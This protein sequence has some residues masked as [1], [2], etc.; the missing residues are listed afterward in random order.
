[1]PRG[2]QIF[3]LTAR[4]MFYRWRGKLSGRGMSGDGIRLRGKCPPVSRAKARKHSM[5]VFTSFI[6]DYNSPHS[7]CVARRNNVVP[8]IP[9]HSIPSVRSPSS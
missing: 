2:F 6:G 7:D 8:T 9:S 1:M 5:H 4:G 3:A